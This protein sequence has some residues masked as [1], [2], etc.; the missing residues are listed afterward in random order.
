MMLMF[1]RV[2]GEIDPSEADGEMRKWF[3]S[4]QDITCL[5]KTSQ[6]CRRAF[7]YATIDIVLEKS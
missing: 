5:G 4:V 2:L 7:G 1:I 3:V 6:S